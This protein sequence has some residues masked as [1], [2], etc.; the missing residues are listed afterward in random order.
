[1]DRPDLV[2]IGAIVVALV[3]FDLLFVELRRILREGKRIASRL[4][5][6]AD[7]PVFAQL[8]ASDRDI[9]RILTA[10]DALP[11]LFARAQAALAVLPF[12]K[13]KGSSSA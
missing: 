4:A 10:L 5:A 7:L 3:F 6:Y 1:M 2:W 9:E 8:A 11:P 12:Y 13:P